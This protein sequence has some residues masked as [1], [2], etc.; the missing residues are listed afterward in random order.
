MSVDHQN[1]SHTLRSV[2]IF[3]LC[4]SQEIHLELV[5][6][7]SWSPSARGLIGLLKLKKPALSPGARA[8]RISS[9]RALLFPRDVRAHC[10]V[11][12]GQ[13]S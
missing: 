9:T 8:T 12:V 2:L 7:N 4:K 11:S 1:R 3:L 10:Q 13:V 5:P 6:E